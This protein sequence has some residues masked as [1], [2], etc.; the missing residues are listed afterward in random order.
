[1]GVHREVSNGSSVATLDLDSKKLGLNGTQT[2]AGDHETEARPI[3]IHDE[4]YLKP[5][6]GPSAWYGSEFKDKDAESR[7]IHVLTQEEIAEIDKA[8]ENVKKSG[9]ETKVFLNS[10]SGILCF[11]CVLTAVVSERYR[12]IMLAVFL[13]NQKGPFLQQTHIYKRL[14]D[15]STSERDREFSN[16]LD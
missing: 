12:L 14:P 8:I 6:V 4:Q 11:S 5:V 13:N 15:G 2:V 10:R 7:W 1:M 9:K 16:Q 3:E